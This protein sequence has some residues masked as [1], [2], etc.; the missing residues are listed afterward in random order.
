VEALYRE[1]AEVRLL[2]QPDVLA[3]NPRFQQ[4]G[5]SRLRENI[6]L[7]TL[8]SSINTISGITAGF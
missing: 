3:Q 1:H 8:R 4:R 7:L 2:A 5:L 6:F